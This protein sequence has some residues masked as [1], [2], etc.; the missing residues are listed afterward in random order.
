MTGL[1]RVHGLHEQRSL[2]HVL[3]AVWP[4]RAERRMHANHKGDDRQTNPDARKP[5]VLWKPA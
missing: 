5:P 2:S 1:R 3:D 4:D